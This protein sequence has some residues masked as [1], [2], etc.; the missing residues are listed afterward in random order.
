LK[1]TTILTQYQ[2]INSQL[3]D[4]KPLFIVGDI[5]KSL[6]I[7]VIIVGPAIAVAIA[8]QV[9]GGWLLN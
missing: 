2:L 4:G 9:I 7:G 1:P 6:L 5:I 3:W 8:F